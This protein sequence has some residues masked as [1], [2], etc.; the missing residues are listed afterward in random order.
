MKYV[1]NVLQC[2]EL[3]VGGSKEV[4]SIVAFKIPSSI[5]IISVLLE[6]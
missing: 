2:C 6:T 5:L 4:A 1:E 3:M